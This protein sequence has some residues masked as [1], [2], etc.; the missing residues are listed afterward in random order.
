M[1]ISSKRLRYADNSRPEKFDTKTILIAFLK[2][3]KP[4]KRNVKTIHSIS[5]S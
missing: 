4:V 5:V 2:K 3:I 1:S